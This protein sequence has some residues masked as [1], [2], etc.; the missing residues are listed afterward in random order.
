MARF[1]SKKS[2]LLEWLGSPDWKEHLD[3]IAAGGMASAGPLMGFLNHEPVLR[4]R[5]AIALG[6]TADALYREHAERGRDIVR[7]LMWRLSE[8]SGNIGWGVPEA[9]GEVLSHC[10]PLA[11]EFHRILFTTILDL[12]FDDNYVDND[13]LRRSCFFA[14][15]RFLA[16]VPEYGDKIRP[17]LVKGL[18]DP[19]MTCRGYAAWALGQL[20]PDLN[21]APLLRALAESGN[22]AEC[23]IT[24][25]DRVATCTAAQLARKTLLREPAL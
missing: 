4:L 18:S 8:E 23:V 10:P 9:F 12:G 20:S 6:R 11:K 2:Q 17:L 22:G 13:V 1:R 16:A 21:E 19:D 25:G 3:A 5:A 14:I 15:G 24:D 7:R